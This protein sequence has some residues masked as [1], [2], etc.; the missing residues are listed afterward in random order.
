MQN[1]KMTLKELKENIYRAIDEYSVNGNILSG[2]NGIR[3]DIEKKLISSINTQLRKIDLCFANRE[4]EINYRFY[5]LKTILYKK[6]MELSKDG[7]FYFPLPNDAFGIYFELCGSVN[8][9]YTVE[10]FGDVQYET[11][12]SDFTGKTEVRYIIPH[13]ILDGVQTQGITIH[14]PN[15]AH[16]YNLTI[17]SYAQYQEGCTE[18]EACLVPAPGY[19][20]A[21]LPKDFSSFKAAR[22]KSGKL[23]EK[24]FV[25]TKDTV[26][27]KGECVREIQMKYHPAPQSFTGEELEETIDLPMVLCDALVYA[28]AA[29]VCPIEEQI[30]FSHLNYKY[31]D[32]M[33]NYYSRKTPA[34]P[35]RNVFLAPKRRR[36]GG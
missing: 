28:V 6:D 15:G 21:Y 20:C 1:Q 34:Q 22:D 10:E 25:F 33:A 27:V 16:I 13:E 35:E 36:L 19:M 29:E 8:I 12:E 17:Y 9:E 32:T 5:P 3:S 7:R 26:S 11:A 23:Y 2:E 24:D 31:Q 30:L 14:S 18:Q 4:K